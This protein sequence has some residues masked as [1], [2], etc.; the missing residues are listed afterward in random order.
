[1]LTRF[2]SMVIIRCITITMF[3]LLAATISFCQT[4]IKGKIFD[5]TTGEPLAGATIQ[6]GSAHTLA[7]LD[8]SFSFKDV[9]PGRQKIK[10]FYVGYKELEDLEVTVGNNET[11]TL[12]LTLTP[13]VKQLNSILVTSMASNSNDASARKL[14]KN[15]IPIVNVLSAQT[16]QLSPDVT[17]GNILQRVSAVTVQRSNSGEGRY[18]IIRGMDQRF[19]TTLVN[20]I[21]IP[22]P[23]FRYRYVPMDLFPSEILDRL[24]VVKS[25]IPSMEGDAVGGVMNLVMKNAPQHFMVTAN[26]AAGIST[27]FSSSRPFEEYAHGAVNP[28]SPAEIF[29]NN[30]VATQNDFS[31]A[32]L[33]FSDRKMP[34]N[35][36]AG[37][38]V[39]GRTL[40]Q[41]LGIIVSGSF[42]NFNRGSNSTLLVPNAQPQ[43]VGDL[44]NQSVISDLYIRK[45]STQTARWALHNKIDYVF[46]SRNTLSLYNMY[47]HMNEFET[48]ST[49]DSVYLNHL[50]DNLMRSRSLVQSI[51]NATLRG[52]HNISKRFGFYWMGSYSLAKGAMPDMAEYDYQSVVNNGAFGY[53]TQTSHREWQHN[54]NQDLSGYLNITYVPEIANTDFYFTFGGM[55]RHRSRDNYDNQYT[56]NP[57]LSNGLPQYWSGFNSANFQ[58][59][60]AGNGAGTITSFNT[61]TY[62][63]HENVSAGYLQV[64]VSPFKK[65]D[66]L[67]GARV[68]HTLQAFETVM[69]K[70]FTGRSGSVEYTDLLPSANI[71]YKLNEKQDI[72]LSYFRSIVRPDF[73]EIIPTQIVGEIFDIKGNDSLKHSQADNYDL[74]YEIFPGGADQISVGAFYKNIYNPI[75]YAI[76]R[77]GGPSAQFFEPEN[78]GTAHNYGFEAVFT[79]YFG[80]FGIAAN[81]TYVKSQITTSKLYFYKDAATNNITSKT[82]EQKRPLQGQ[83][84]NLGNLS[85]LYKNQKIGLDLQVAFVYTGKR[86]AQVSPYYNL[87]YWQLGQ[88]TLDFSFEKTIFKKCS[89]YGKVNNLTNAPVRT[90][91]MQ[92]PPTDISLPDQQYTSKTVVGKDIYHLNALI[93]FRYKF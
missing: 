90:V 34:I 9:K 82:L 92:A 88:G 87:D 26:A 23:D 78:F 62:T 43:L 18:A 38:T 60:P 42:Q 40:H 37:L 89:L 76:V 57:V 44:N 6:L 52:D 8:G 64:S 61:N 79:K 54:K 49:Y 41:K 14:E 85:L 72:R 17:V 68:E 36:T 16:I 13:N 74:K 7:N 71:K 91:I 51:Y 66:V 10:A 59:S 50:S 84:N 25:L 11:K 33:N 39:G 5:S 22:S 67:A 15:A 75:E 2:F 73:Y 86:I 56:L 21:K 83:A 31:R 20:G 48:R 69:P 81:Y 28:K 70:T 29:G 46:N 24:E 63:S 27:L 45:Y 35:S 55:Y 93:G 4:Q 80:M 12:N 19:N 47:V 30:Y 58:F 1:M 77:N 32:N 3:L 53:I 65:L